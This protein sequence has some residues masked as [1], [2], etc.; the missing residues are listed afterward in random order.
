MS[1]VNSIMLRLARSAV[2][3]P[4]VPLNT[5]FDAAR[6]GLNLNSRSHS[7]RIL[8]QAAIYRTA[9]LGRNERLIDLIDRSVGSV[10]SDNPKPRVGSRKRKKKKR[11]KKQNPG[12]SQADH[13]QPK[14]KRKAKSRRPKVSVSPPPKRDFNEEGRRIL[15]R[16]R[17]DNK[18]MT[19]SKSIVHEAQT[20]MLFNVRYDHETDGPGH[21]SLF[22]ATLHTTLNEDALDELRSQGIA[23]IPSKFVNTGSDRSKKRAEVLACIDLISNLREYGLDLT[24]GIPDVANRIRQ[25]EEAKF[26]LAVNQAQ[27]ILQAMGITRP[28][29]DT[30]QSGKAGFQSTIS[31]YCRGEP[32]CIVD[33]EGGPSKEEAEGKAILVA[34]QPGGQLEEW[35]IKLGLKERLDQVRHLIEESP[36]G[37]IGTLKIPQLSY[38]AFDKMDIALDGHEQRMDWHAKVKDEYEQKFHQRNRR[39]P[40][41]GASRSLSSH[42]DEDDEVMN[43]VFQSE[44]QRR[45]EKSE[46]DPNG[47]Q[48]EIKSIRDKLPIVAIREQ[49]IDALRS[50]QC[51]VVSGG[52]GSGKSTQCPQYI[53]EDAIA[54]GKG[55]A[56]K[57]VVT[58]PRRIAAISVAERIASERDEEIGRSVGY[59]VRFNRRAPRGCASIEFVTT[60]ILL[61]RLVNDPTLQGVSHVCLDEVHERVSSCRCIALLR[62]IVGLTPGGR[63][64]TLIFCWCCCATCSNP[65]QTCA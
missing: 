22:Y 63:T 40:A 1:N 3:K 28:S 64:S 12:Q 19:R 61:R 30:V 10:A 16:S 53:L 4:C 11:K 47:T 54:N 50:S 21:E 49:L 45:L 48:A 25:K 20:K 2:R 42:G 34:T 51:V 17:A 15:F 9:S 26:K 43:R 37:H 18:L 29:F 35:L 31:F 14:A 39:S 38:E 46:A 57:I 58:Q 36:T 62:S 52:T 24:E 41:E 60:G 55:T 44:E 8:P 27:M 56:T 6:R 33:H 5:S 23:S 65:G 13:A 32:M 59:N 7:S